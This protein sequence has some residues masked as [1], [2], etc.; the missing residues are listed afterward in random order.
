MGI[1]FDRSVRESREKEVDGVDPFSIMESS[2][3]LQ[4]AYL[5]KK[6]S[7]MQRLRTSIPLIQR[8]RSPENGNP[9]RW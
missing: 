3:F 8:I 2:H 1:G 6:M 5:K 7:F 9:G 4:N